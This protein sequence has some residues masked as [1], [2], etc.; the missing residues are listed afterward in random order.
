MLASKEEVSVERIYLYWWLRK[1]RKTP[2]RPLQCLISDSVPLPDGVVDDALLAF[3]VTI[4]PYHRN[5]NKLGSCTNYRYS[6]VTGDPSIE[7][8]QLIYFIFLSLVCLKCMDSDIY[9]N[10]RMKSNR[11]FFLVLKCLYFQSWLDFRHSSFRIFGS[12]IQKISFVLKIV[13]IKN[14]FLII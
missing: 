6:R 5:L 13:K 9:S 3:A 7:F 8:I 4:S 14:K 12:K 11:E 1:A 10:S 2:V